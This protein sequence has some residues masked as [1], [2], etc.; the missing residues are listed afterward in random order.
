LRG[1]GRLPPAVSLRRQPASLT[2]S[3]TISCHVI[4]REKKK[5]GEERDKE[6]DGADGWIRTAQCCLGLSAQLRLCGAHQLLKV[7]VFDILKV[8][9]FYLEPTHIIT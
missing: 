7:L 2:T 3:F 1:A 9:V 8:L 6:R 5:R 4:E